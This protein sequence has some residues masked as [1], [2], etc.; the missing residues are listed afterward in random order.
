[1]V[2]KEKLKVESYYLL[3]TDDANFLYRFIIHVI[4]IYRKVMTL[5]I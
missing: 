5:L 1:M 4:L 3:P 2:I